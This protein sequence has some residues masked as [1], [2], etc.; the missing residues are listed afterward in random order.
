[1]LL[2]SLLEFCDATSLIAS[3][4]TALIG[5]VVDLGT[6]PRDIGNGAPVFVTF[7]IDTAVSGGTSNQ[8]LIAS[9]SGE[10]ID[11]TSPP[12][13]ATIHY[14][15]DTFT[16][17]ELVAGFQW[18]VPLPMGDVGGAATVYERYLG[19]LSTDLGGASAGA[20]S[21]YAHLDAHGWRSYPDASN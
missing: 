7:H 20:I 18:T 19:I 15:S 4:G 21:V 14:T 12:T 17:A 10:A 16:N 5:S 9:D 13:S 3:A 11:A 1:M 8:F 6:V 2:D